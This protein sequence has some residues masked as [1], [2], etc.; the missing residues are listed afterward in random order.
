M[1]PRNGPENVPPKSPDR[2]AFVPKTVQCG[3]FRGYPGKQTPICYEA[4]LLVRI[5]QKHR[6]LCADVASATG[7]VILFVCCDWGTC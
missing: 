7:A 2:A 4:M 5:H 6:P 1:L 3:D